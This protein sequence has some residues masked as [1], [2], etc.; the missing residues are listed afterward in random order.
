MLRKWHGFLFAYAQKPIETTLAFGTL[1][2]MAFPKL[3]HFIWFQGLEHAPSEIRD[4]PRQW[5]TLNPGWQVAF[6][7]CATLSRF[8]RT[9]YSSYF[10]AWNSL[11]SVIKKCDF[12]R[13]LL[14][15][16]FGGV[17]ADMDLHPCR[18]LESFLNAGEVRHRTTFATGRLPENGSV[19]R[20]PLN[21]RDLIFT[22]EYQTV[23]DL[24]WPIANG[25][26]FAKP[27][28]NLWLDFLDSR[29]SDT[30]A[31]VLNYVGPWA[32]TRF[33]KAKVEQLR[34]RATVLPPYYFL[35][36]PQH[37]YMEQ[38]EWVVSTHAAKNY[39]GDHTKPDWWNT[40]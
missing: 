3:V 39:W 7:D 21:E 9:H 28:L 12:A 5:E 11:P 1:F 32:L 14:L 10:H 35:W 19:E 37:F 23:P 26:I 18:S 2:A 38:P 33:V 8:I 40:H 36:E 25:I 13:V 15:F 6:W 27:H 20:V 22:R 34:G 29:L 24:G 4:N 17:Y 31:A 16:H 30:K